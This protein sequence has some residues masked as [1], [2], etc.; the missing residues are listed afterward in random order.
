MSVAVTGLYAGILGIVFFV[1]SMRVISNRVRAK[2]NL[3]DGGDDALTRAMRVHGNFTEYVPFALL[4]MALAEIQGGSG[5]FIHVLG[6]VLI[7]CRL[8]HAY[9]ITATTGQNPFRFIG[10]VGTFCV[11]FAAGGYSIYRFAAAAV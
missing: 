3:L 8:S 10:F 6:T 7:V 9:A 11:I 5:L 2:V 4:L 1:L